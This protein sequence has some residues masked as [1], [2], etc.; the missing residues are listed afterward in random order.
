MCDAIVICGGA[1]I[2]I[3]A[4]IATCNIETK[5][6]GDYELMKK[7]LESKLVGT[8][9]KRKGV[10]QLVKAIENLKTKPTAFLPPCLANVN[11]IIPLIVTKDVRWHLLRNAHQRSDGNAME[12]MEWRVAHATWHRVRG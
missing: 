3:E 6:S 7:Y 2:L 11:K 9:T 8:P 4:K 12:I 5:Y 1:A 10:W